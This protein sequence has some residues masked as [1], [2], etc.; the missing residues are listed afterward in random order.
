[1]ETVSEWGG[2]QMTEIPMKFIPTLGL[3]ALCSMLTV[4][5]VFGTLV[6]AM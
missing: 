6:S 1:M 2:S 5:P 3:A 4:V